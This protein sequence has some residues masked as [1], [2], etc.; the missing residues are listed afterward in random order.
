MV[1]EHVDQ[2]LKVLLEKLQSHSLPIS[3]TKV[4][5]N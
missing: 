2:D 4:I 5:I 3:F 1:F